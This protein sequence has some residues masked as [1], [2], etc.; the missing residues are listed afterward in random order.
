MGSEANLRYQKA[1]LAVTL[2]ELE[3]L[4]EMLAE[5]SAAVAE[6][7][8]S[9]R[10]M[11]QKTS[12]LSRSERSLQAALDKERVSNAEK[13]K[14][15]EGLERELSLLRRQSDDSTKREKSG[16][17]DV[18]SKDVRLNRALEELE[19]TKSQ[20]K[21]L[22]EQREGAG[23]GARA[24]AQRLA[25]ENNKLRKRQSELILAFKKQAK[26]IDVLKRQ[27]LHAEA[28]MMLGFTE[29]EFE[30]SLELGERMLA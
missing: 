14:Q 24:E 13:A 9:V 16:V 2:E 21:Q 20:L 26:L 25:A 6:A 17:A 29:E 15:A 18:R 1:R 7:E 22:R 4:R 3:R 19:R 10:D 8:A 23:S 30:R 11:Q 28:A 5:K 27:K 12:L